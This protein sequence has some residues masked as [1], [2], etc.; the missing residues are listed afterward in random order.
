MTRRFA[1]R[2]EVNLSATAES[3]DQHTI[4]R[5]WNAVSEIRRSKRFF[6]GDCRPAAVRF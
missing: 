2:A 4:E 6:R 3:G 1:H 5:L